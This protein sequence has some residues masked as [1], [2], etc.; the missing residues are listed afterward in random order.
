MHEST[1]KAT[2]WTQSI[3]INRSLSP[4]PTN[5]SSIA[6]CDYLSTRVPNARHVSGGRS[7]AIGIGDAIAPPTHLFKQQSQPKA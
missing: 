3:S 4:I 2:V 1:A 7:K 5:H 6:S